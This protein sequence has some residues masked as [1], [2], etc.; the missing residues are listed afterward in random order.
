M[1]P[2]RSAWGTGRLHLY[3]DCAI[4]SNYKMLYSHLSYHQQAVQNVDP[5]SPCSLPQDRLQPPCC[6]IGASS[7]QLSDLPGV[8]ADHAGNFR[9]PTE[10]SPCSQGDAGN[11][12]AQP[13]MAGLRVA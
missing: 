2:R 11:V 7:V 8:M 1:G 12:R 6:P 10:F 9:V 5:K 3:S 13:A 4:L